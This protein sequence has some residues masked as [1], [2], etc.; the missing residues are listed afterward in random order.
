MGARGSSS[1]KGEPLLVFWDRKYMSYICMCKEYNS[2]LCG[3]KVLRVKKMSSHLKY[4]DALDDM[5]LFFG[6]SNL[7]LIDFE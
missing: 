4:L 6:S 3:V 7:F 5:M 1:A 2:F